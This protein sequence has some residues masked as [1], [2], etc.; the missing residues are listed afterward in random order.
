MLSF[1]DAVFTYYIA[2]SPI[3]ILSNTYKIGEVYISARNL[4]DWYMCRRSR[5]VCTGT[6]S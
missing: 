3:K 1:D 2:D 5:R 6:N 4:C